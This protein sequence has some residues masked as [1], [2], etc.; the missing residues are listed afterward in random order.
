M[1][2]GNTNFIAP[3]KEIDAV[4]VAKGNCFCNIKFSHQ[5]SYFSHQQERANT[6]LPVRWHSLHVGIMFG[7]CGTLYQFTQDLGMGVRVFS[8]VSEMG[9]GYG[10]CGR[11]NL[12]I[13]L[14]SIAVPLFT[15]QQLRRGPCVFLICSL[16]TTFAH[17]M[18]LARQIHPGR[19]SQNNTSDM[20]LSNLV[21][22]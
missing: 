6:S 19:N 14:D 10:V 5:N 18:N 15:N 21:K 3:P 8:G 13:E 11:Y 16:N 9:L 1:D 4:I 7:F 22:F 12:D 2:K 20:F 17:Q